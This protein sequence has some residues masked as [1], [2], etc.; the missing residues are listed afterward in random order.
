MKNSKG[1]QAERTR[2]PERGS[3]K[4]MV[5]GEPGR[6][7]GERGEVFLKERDQSKRLASRA[8]GYRGGWTHGFQSKGRHHI[9]SH[10]P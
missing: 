4:S 7:E 3:K 9:S 1:H 8:W 6:K 10:G 2:A 5:I